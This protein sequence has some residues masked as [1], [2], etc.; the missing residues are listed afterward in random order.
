MKI[1]RLTRHVATTEQ[2]EDLRRIYGGDIEVVEVSETVPNADRVA[3]LA[4]E[5]RADVVEAV[6]PL[7][8]LAQA[9]QVVHIP[10]IRAITRRE[11]RE[12]GTKPEFVFDH[13][14]RYTRVVVEMERL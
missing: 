1:L 13:Y 14:E 5:H 11:L 8:L 10:I 3:A 6:L 9:M 2:I 7:G 12:D 4:F